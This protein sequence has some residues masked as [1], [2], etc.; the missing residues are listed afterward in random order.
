MTAG[1]PRRLP[2]DDPDRLTGDLQGGEPPAHPAVRGGN[3]GRLGH[4]W[5]FGE[6]GD[7]SIWP[8]RREIPGDRADTL[9]DIEQN[10]AE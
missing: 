6:L 4:Q 5:S 9:F 8:S 3:P 1:S 7:L 2:A 10:I